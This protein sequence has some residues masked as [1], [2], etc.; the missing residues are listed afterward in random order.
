MRRGG[1]GRPS[2]T[3]GSTDRAA[4]PLDRY[5][6]SE[7]I[8]LHPTV[9]G[10]DA[11]GLGRPRARS[12]PEL[13]HPGASS[14]DVVRPDLYASRASERGGALAA[15]VEL[16]KQGLDVGRGITRGRGGAHS[17]SVPPKN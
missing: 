2:R 17:P 10:T 6:K 4:R 3:L 7:G 1:S 8:P 13:R 16:G 14:A 11:L 5:V 15:G 12:P 9:A